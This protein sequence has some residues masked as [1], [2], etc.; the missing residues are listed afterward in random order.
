MRLGALVVAY[1]CVPASIIMSVYEGVALQTT[2]DNETLYNDDILDGRLIIEVQFA[3]VHK[4]MSVS[5][6][7]MVVLTRDHVSQET[8]VWLLP[9]GMTAA[10]WQ[11][12]QTQAY[13]LATFLKK[14]NARDTQDDA[15]AAENIDFVHVLPAHEQRPQATVFVV[16]STR[17]AD[18]LGQVPFCIYF[19]VDTNAETRVD[20]TKYACRNAHTTVH[21]TT[22][23]TVCVDYDC[24]QVVRIPLTGDTIETRK[25]GPV[26]H[27]AFETQSRY[28][29]HCALREPELSY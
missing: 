20:T 8:V 28:L 18:G 15:W 25:H 7:W 6:E 29:A 10:A 24:T 5:Y 11:L 17:T 14:K 1:Y 2:A 12:L 21:S 22:H 23:A 19:L 4:R 9:G 3:N 27:C 13:N 16:G 26:R